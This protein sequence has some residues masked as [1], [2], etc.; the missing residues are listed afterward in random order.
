MLECLC[1]KHSDFR[2]GILRLALSLCVCLIRAVIAILLF[3][4]HDK[5]QCGEYSRSL[6]SYVLLSSFSI[7]WWP[8]ADKSFVF[9]IALVIS[10]YLPYF[11]GQCVRDLWSVYIEIDYPTS[12]AYCVYTLI[13][14][15]WRHRHPMTRENDDGY[16][17]SLDNDT[18]ETISN[19]IGPVEL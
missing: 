1:Q 12:I 8:F 2:C 11:A 16:N 13:V 4:Y 9:S 10:G 18:I 19:P 15:W 5:A 6:E 7:I 3:Q 14:Q 17:D